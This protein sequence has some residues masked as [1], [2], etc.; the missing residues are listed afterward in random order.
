M[1]VLPGAFMIFFLCV[2][3]FIEAGLADA[4]AAGESSGS[5]GKDLAD[6]TRRASLMP[7]TEPKRGLVEFQV[8]P[9]VYDGARPDLGDLRVLAGNQPLAW[10]L[11]RPRGTQR[12]VL[13]DASLFNPTRI[14]GQVNRVMVDFDEPTMKDHIQIVTPGIDFKRSVAVEA[15][16]DAHQWEILRE[17][18]F[19]FDV[20]GRYSKDRISLPR[21]DFRFLRISV[22]HDSDDPEDVPIRR[23]RAWRREGE[24]APL[25]TVPVVDS[26]VEL[27]RDRNT[28]LITIDLA[29]RNL[30]LRRLHLDFEEGNFHRQVTLWGRN[31]KTRVVTRR[32]ESG[33]ER[34]VTTEAP[35]HRIG[36]GRIHRYTAGDSV[37]ASL[38]L[39]LTGGRFRYVQVRIDDGDN[40]PL[41]FLSA[42]ADRYVDY[43]A[44]KP[45]RPGPYHL[46]FANPDARMPDYDLVHYERRLRTEG[47]TVANVREPVALRAERPEETIFAE[48]YN[49][50]LW[51]ALLAAVA[52][53]SLAVWR[54]AKS[55]RK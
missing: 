15:S 52:V 19:L 9:A 28:T 1:K 25:E 33:A 10:V 6:W 40:S 12:N 13:I 50:V 8:P 53:L 7:E 26:S 14:P 51:I 16:Q 21:N 45:I 42:E 29:Y 3:F 35:W 43:V 22:Y 36:P 37:A 30:P 20:S 39:P 47:V 23:V 38:S 32:L 27:D 31:K 17:E 24:P 55:V 48:V 46:Y 34:R 11:R 4:E 41:S 2:V 49:R 18:A 5:Y 54:Q 44:F